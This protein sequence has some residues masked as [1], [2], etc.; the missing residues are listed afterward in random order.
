MSEREQGL[1]SEGCMW[2]RVKFIEKLYV[3][4]KV[5]NIVH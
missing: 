2:V 5:E 1:E 3:L 4:E